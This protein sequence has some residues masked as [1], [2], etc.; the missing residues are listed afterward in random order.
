VII[1]KRAIDQE[2]LT[3]CPLLLSQLLYFIA[4]LN[5]VDK[6]L[7]RFKTRD[8]ML[9][10]YDCCIAG[11][12]SRYFFLSFLIDET[13]EPTNVDVLATRHRRFYNT[14]ECFYGC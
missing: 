6:D 13:S 1:D 2:P 7:G 11:N 5:L 10:N 9:V 14:K 12:I 3:Y 8:V 4:V